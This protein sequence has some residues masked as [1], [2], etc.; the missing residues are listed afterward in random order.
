M[1]A[2]TISPVAVMRISKHAEGAMTSSVSGCLVGLDS[3]TGSLEV[4]NVFLHPARGAADFQPQQTAAEEAAQGASAGGAEAAAVGAAASY[5]AE[6]IRLF[7]AANLDGN[8]VGWFQSSNLSSFIN[9][10]TVEIQFDYQSQNPNNV[11]VVADASFETPLKAFRLTEEYMAFHKAM[12]ERQNQSPAT[13]I[14][15]GPVCF[16]TDGSMHVF[17]EV[18][19]QVDL[20]V[21]DEA[22][23]FEHRQ[24]LVDSVGTSKSTNSETC[25]QLL[26]ECVEDLA[27]EKVRFAQLSAGKTSFGTTRVRGEDEV[28][29]LQSANAIILLTENVRRLSQTLDTVAKANLT[30]CEIFEALRQ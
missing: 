16:R 1:T 20:S 26:M 17:E 13:L 30:T 23:L 11:L 27:V 18:E 9:E 21:L 29:R 3:D 25:M 22:F 2:V 14:T 15:G 5:Q 8:I 19:V 7:K 10:A 12:R 28:K 4:T 6:A 24:R